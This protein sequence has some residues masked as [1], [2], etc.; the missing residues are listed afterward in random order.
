M[1]SR[2]T[3]ILLAAPS[4]IPSLALVL[5]VVIG[6][7]CLNAGNSCHAQTLINGANQP[8]IIYTNTLVDSYIFTANVGDSINLRLGATNFNG[9]LKLDGPDG[10]SLATVPTAPGFE[11]PDQLITYT[12]T[13]SGVFTVQVSSYDGRTGTYVLNLS[14][15]PEPFIV[16]AGYGGGPLTNGANATG[17]ITLARQ[18]LWT[19]TANAGDSI[20]VRLGTTGFNGNLELY[21]PNGALLKNV[22]TAPGDASLD[23]LITYVPTN[24]GTFTVLVSS[25]DADGGGN[26]GAYV[27]NLSQIPE[28]F[29]VPAGYGGGPLTNGANA[30]GT[31]T[32]G[33]QDLWTFTANA[34]DSINVRLGT[35]NFYGKLELY[36]PDGT[37]LKNIPASQGAANMDQ[38]ISAYAATN[39]GTFTV[40][41]SS[42]FAEGTGTYVLNLSQIPEPFIVPAGYRGGPLTNGVSETGTITLARQDLW[43]FAANPGDSIH[44]RLETTTFDGYLQLYAPNGALVEEV[45]ASQGAASTNLL[46]TDTSTNSG[47]FTVL[48]SSYFAEGTGTYVLALSQSPGVPYRMWAQHYFGCTNCSQALEFA[49]PDGNSVDNYDEF[50]SGFNPS[51]SAAYPHI[52]NIAPTNSSTDV[53]VTY[54]GASGDS[55]YTGG[56]VSRTNVL[57]FTTGAANG[58]YLNSFV[59]TGHTNILSGGTGLG[60]VTN[61]VDHGGATNQPSRYYRIQ[62]I[63]P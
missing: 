62:V 15:I 6:S 39:S 12:P 26:T 42:Y 46:I 23:Q 33:R 48:V 2:F 51:N 4:A 36:G 25:Y 57:E 41:V 21:A 50:A 34:G 56:P 63:T 5:A 45:P 30:T 24:S 61:M 7:T 3:S 32:L 16:P 13:N 35:T 11:G 17:T 18:D 54:L 9:R 53:L 22:P 10:A 55:T 59:S 31:I 49:D 1:K 40:L 38:L 27:L 19:F 8:G 29:I 44:V 60:I 14:Q 37:L 52:L 20:N 43:T 28:P 47:T 58:S